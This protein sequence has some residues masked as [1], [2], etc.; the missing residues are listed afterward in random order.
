MDEK[1]KGSKLSNWISV[2]YLFAALWLLGTV[3]N[4]CYPALTEPVITYLIG[5]EDNPVREAFSTF[6]NGVEQGNA[7]PDVVSASVEVLLGEKA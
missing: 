6:V 1:R 3:C 4:T 2:L 5:M 7:M